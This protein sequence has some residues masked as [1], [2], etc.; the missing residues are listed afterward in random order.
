MTQ[1]S[2]LTKTFLILCGLAFLS[3]A[4]QALYDPQLIMDLVQD[5]LTN[6]SSRNSIRAMYGGVHLALGAYLIYSAI[7][8]AKSALVLLALYTGGFFFG[9][10][11][12]FLTD[13]TDVTPFIISWTFTEFTLFAISTALLIKLRK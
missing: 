4:L 8:D 1:V 5:K 12:G 13:G 10:I 2:T 3:I 6:T 11:T 9:R 7:K